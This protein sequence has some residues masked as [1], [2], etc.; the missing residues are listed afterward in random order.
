ML[1]L[2]FLVKEDT[3]NISYSLDTSS[4]PLCLVLCYNTNLLK[5]S[6]VLSNEHEV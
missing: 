5:W 3:T 2:A 4:Y 1:E 6:L